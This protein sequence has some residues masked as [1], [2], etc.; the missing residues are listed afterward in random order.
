MFGSCNAMPCYP[1]RH[2][3]WSI[4]PNSTDRS[5]LCITWF[6]ANPI[7]LDYSAAYLMYLVTFYLIF[8]RSRFTANSVKYR[9]NV[10]TNDIFRG[11]SSNMTFRALSYPTRF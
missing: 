9:P 8:S 4:S 1:I 3:R 5:T 6:T 11:L 2:T 7:K 10:Y